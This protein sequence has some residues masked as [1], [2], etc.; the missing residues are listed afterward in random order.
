[1]KIN[2]NS[3]PDKE[4]WVELRTPPSFIATKKLIAPPV[5]ALPCMWS[6]EIPLPVLPSLPDVR[7]WG[8]RCHWYLRDTSV[9]IPRK[10]VSLW[11]NRNTDEITFH[12]TPALSTSHPL[13]P[14]E[15]PS[16][17]GQLWTLLVWPL[18]PKNSWL[19]L[20]DSLFQLQKCKL[21]SDSSAP[22][23]RQA[24][25]AMSII[26]SFTWL[27]FHGGLKINSKMCIKIKPFAT[28]MIIMK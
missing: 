6:N 10:T 9:A 8:E 26:Q 7:V 19:E 12:F 28:I 13:C 27:L 24:A 23:A 14:I 22:S 5:L 1:M 17:R 15:S 25:Y 20:S 3:T 16:L 11:R 21:L 18:S 2:S 4:N